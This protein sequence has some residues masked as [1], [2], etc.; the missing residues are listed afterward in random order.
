MTG[1]KSVNPA[2]QTTKNMRTPLKDLLQKL[3]VN[4]VL[5]AYETNPWMHYD[6]DQGITCSAEVRMGPSCTDL[7][8]EI[9]F[10]YDDPEAA[11]KSNPQQIM[12]MRAVPTMGDLWA[13]KTMHVQGNHLS[14]TLGGW[15]EKGCN[16]FL[17]CVQ[18]LQMG[19]LPNIE[20]LVKKELP[21]DDDAKGGRGR[22]GRKSP[23]VNSSAL[24]GMKK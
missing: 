24:L 8:A 18:A 22:I 6:E 13:P 12:V 14:E 10:L 5:S 15:E 21:D 20:E 11:H 1:A 9:Q 16:F 7:E 2:R 3:G 19:E 4:R 23:K 17:A